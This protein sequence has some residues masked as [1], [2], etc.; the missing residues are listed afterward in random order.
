MTATKFDVGGYKLSAEISGEGS[1]TVVFISGSGDA[2]EAWDA[3]ISA[4]RSSST[5]VTYARAGIGDS[6]T[7]VDPAPRSV[8]AATEELRRLLVATNIAGPFILVGHSIGALIGLIFAA[9]WPENLA[10]L[11][12]VDATDIHL[13][14]ETEEP[15]TFVVDGDREDHLSFDVPASLD[16]VARSRR[17]VDVP[18]VVL[19][20][21]VG[22]WLDVAD[23]EPWQ[24]FTLAE[25]D[26]R[27]QRHH[28]S[29]AAD[30]GAV[31]KVARFGGHYIQKD[32]PTIVAEAIDNLV[33]S[34]RQR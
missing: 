32:D 26:E 33:E 1:P 34:A 14:L 18:S 11:V 10:G 27:W 30:L 17:V 8:G 13:N 21:R 6:E 25:L 28:Q 4:L 12:L 3:A 24:P 20:S 7:P 16:E 23:P 22:R 19:T 29:L 31:H 2:G 5:L 9:Q 15:H